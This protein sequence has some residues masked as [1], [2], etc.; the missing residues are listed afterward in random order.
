MKKIDAFLTILYLVICSIVLIGLIIFTENYF[1]KVLVGIVIIFWSLALTRSY[2]L[3]NY[4]RQLD[5]K[6]KLNFFEHLTGVLNNWNKIVGLVITVKPLFDKNEFKNER[7]LIN[8]L[9]FGI[10][11][12][13]IVMVFIIVKFN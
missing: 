8:L 5:T 3:E 10:Y 12:I 4:L 7:Q 13:L 2:H 9:T 11:L 6:S 1:D